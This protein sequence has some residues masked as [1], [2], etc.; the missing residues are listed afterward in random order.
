MAEI[1]VRAVPIEQ[2]LERA[3]DGAPEAAARLIEREQERWETVRSG[4][5]LILG[6]EPE[7]EP[8]ITWALCSRHMWVKLVAERGWP[9]DRYQSWLAATVGAALPHDV[10][11]TQP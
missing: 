11:T 3:A 6:G 7:P 5:R 2:V 1:Q 10:I 9:A 4:L 8:D